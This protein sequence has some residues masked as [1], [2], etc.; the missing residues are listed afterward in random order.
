MTVSS[1]SPN[2]ERFTPFGSFGLRTALATALLGAFALSGCGGSDSATTGD[3][4]ISHLSG[5]ATKASPKGAVSPVAALPAGVDSMQVSFMDASGNLVHGP[6]EVAAAPVVDI[7]EVPLAAKSA[8]VDYLRNGGYA[9]ATDNEPITWNGAS[10]SAS[11]TPTG[12]G[13]SK[14]QWQASMDSNGIASIKLSIDGQPATEFLAKG[15]AYSPAPIGF[16]NKD[17][18]SFGDIFWDTPGGF[19][20]FE[21]V[22]KRDIENIRSAGFNAL[23]TYSLI[24]NFINNDGSIPSPGDITKPGSLLVR[25]HKKFLDEAWNNGVNPVYVIV[26]IPMPDTIYVKSAF[27]AP[28]NA[29]NNQ[30]WDDNFTATIAQMKDHPAVIGFTIFNEV[31]GRCHYAD[32]VPPAPKTLDERKCEGSKDLEL[33]WQQLHTYP[34]HY[35]SQVKK[36]ADRAKQMAPDKLI[37][38]AFNDDAD[39]AAVTVQYRK[40]YAQSIDFYGVNVFQAEQLNSAL[41][42]WLK[43]KQAEAARPILMT[44]YGLPATGHR[45]P[46]DPLSIYSD[47]NTIKLTATAVGKL[48]PKAFEHPVVTGMFYFEWSDEWWKQPGNG[49]RNDR[50][51]GISTSNDFPNKYWDEEGFGLYSIALGDRAANQVYTDNL[52]GKGGNVQVDKLTPRTELLDTVVNAFKNAEKTRNTALGPK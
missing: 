34:V 20:D 32:P 29:K 27:D 23:R 46:N 50:Q 33:Y 31:G 49:N 30:F 14:T 11:P 17:G 44:E 38:W 39:F 10:G 16:S 25:Q 24:S 5:T 35:W 36:Y 6:I 21:R 26:G 45:N 3:V 4:T 8:A 42:P 1:T 41:N 51:E 22:W 37:G 47:A 40:Q 9:L 52:G 18:P 48:I 13:P 2:G 7:K 12:A 15:V 28:G 19:L 43:E